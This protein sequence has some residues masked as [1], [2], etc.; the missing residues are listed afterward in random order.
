MARLNKEAKVYIVQRLACFEPAADI[1][2]GVKETYGADVSPQALQTYDPTKVNGQSLSAPLK[3]IFEQT[4]A[5][6]LDNTADIPIASK[7]HR[8]RVMN[9]LA[10]KA[11]TKGNFV[12]ALQVIVEASK[13]CGDMRVNRRI[14]QLK[15]PAPTDNTPGPEYTLSPDE[16]VPTKPIL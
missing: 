16:D 7:A 13:E 8:L 6:Y 9:R 3:E 11:E 1:I 12:F 15:P 14:E 10:E 4:R 2:K 5:K